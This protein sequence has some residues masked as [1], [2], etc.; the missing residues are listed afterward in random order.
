MA[1]KNVEM[2]KQ[3]ADADVYQWQGSNTAIGK[4]GIRGLEHEG[5]SNNLGVVK[6]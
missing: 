2:K 5:T 4:F 1:N 6:Q 3:F